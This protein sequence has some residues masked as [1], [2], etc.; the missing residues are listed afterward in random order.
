MNR[1]IGS[2]LLAVVLACVSC[3]GE[4]NPAGPGDGGGGGG[5]GGGGNV[6]TA[7]IDGQ[8][9]KAD[10]NLIFVTGNATPTRQ[11]AL[12]ITG[13]QASSGITLGLNLAFIIGPATQ[14]LGVNAGT[15]PGG[16]VTI[17]DSPDVW[18]TP[19]NGAAGFVTITA[20]TATRIAGTFH[21]TAATL[22]P[23]AA[24]TRSVTDGKFDITV[25]AG[26]PDLPTGVGSTA[27][28]SIGGT[29]WNAATI[30]GINP[31]GGTFSVAAD[32]TAYSITL[33]PKQPV[34][35]GN[36]YGIPS[37]MTVQVIRTGTTDSWW[38]GLGADVGTITI[39]TLAA[40]RLVATFSGNLVALNASGPLAVTGGAI[41]AYLEN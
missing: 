10:G 15:T 37:Q 11:G 32:N 13:S 12:L 5:G 9:W 40:D 2:A 26:L 27:I 39:T 14:P 16:T 17:T 29:P 7:T 25:P 30:V 35:A 36:T 8:P 22:P 31:G 38:G 6:F 21:C 23:A 41:N 20:R 28:A 1:W 3:G 24:G 33:L 34:S 19:L 18:M 4:D